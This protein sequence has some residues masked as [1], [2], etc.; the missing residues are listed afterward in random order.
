MDII[1]DIRIGGGGA[2]WCEGGAAA[3]AGSRAALEEAAA[4]A[5]ICDMKCTPGGG[6]WFWQQRFRLNFERCD[7]QRWVMRW[8]LG[9]V[10]P[11]SWLPLATGREFTQPR[12]HLC[13]NTST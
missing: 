13:R 6:V 3:A 4:A 2:G 11:A 5:A 12:A 9:C 7:V 1:G 8:T 10:N